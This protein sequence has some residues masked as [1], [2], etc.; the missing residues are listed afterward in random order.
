[1]NGEIVRNPLEK[2]LRKRRAMALP[3]ALVVL[4][5]AGVLVAGSMYL[6][7]NMTSVNQ[8][9][10]DDELRMNAANS[11]IEAGKRWVF[12]SIGGSVALRR[13]PDWGK[14][15]SA[16]AVISDLQVARFSSVVDGVDVESVVY[17]V[18]FE[19]VAPGLD[20]GGDSM[21]LFGRSSLS[22][23]DHSTGYAPQPV[24][25]AYVIRSR[26]AYKGI[27]KVLEQGLVVR[28]EIDL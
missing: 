1:M 12:Q 24:Q 15:L 16:T 6:I 21:P 5:V 11:G 26:A 4:L 8:A 14:E 2:G 19:G 22:S 10:V 18:L 17:D 7:E 28:K 3:L 23:Y 13:R 20:F 9:K 25:G 27:E